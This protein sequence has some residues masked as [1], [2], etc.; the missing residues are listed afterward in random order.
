MVHWGGW[1]GGIHK[2]NAPWILAH[3]RQGVGRRQAERVS[4]RS[5]SR[6][7]CHLVFAGWKIEDGEC[8]GP[9]GE[10]KQKSEKK[11]KRKNS[12]RTAKDWTTTGDGRRS[13]CKSQNF[14]KKLNHSHKMPQ[15]VQKKK[16]LKKI[17]R[18]SK[19]KTSTACT[20]VHFQHASAYAAK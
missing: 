14:D 18:L 10:T 19:P 17:E 2:H 5:T 16:S 8:E 6:G 9:A 7:A 11:S 20:V 4:V 1:G 3:K 15:N 13:R 12:R